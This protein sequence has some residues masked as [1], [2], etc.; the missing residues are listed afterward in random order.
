MRD[1]RRI[2]TIILMS[3]LLLIVA[4]CQGGDAG[5]T[6][7]GSGVEGTGT[8][9]ATSDLNPQE[10]TNPG[11]GMNPAEISYP[12]GDASVI[13]V[14]RE[15]NEASTLPMFLL[16][17]RSLI[18]PDDF[19]SHIDNFMSFDYFGYDYSLSFY[20]FPTDADPYYLTEI[21]WTNEDYDL[22]GLRIGDNMDDAIVSITSHGFTLTST[23]LNPEFERDGVLIQLYGEDVITSIEIQFPSDYVSGNIY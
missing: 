12:P 4:G 11:E 21:T 16:S 5:T 3:S 14:A 15:I 8:A 6:S 13:Q 22:F 1:A 9:G 18:N 10:H 7:G 20:G 17:P 23:T 19:E 2:I